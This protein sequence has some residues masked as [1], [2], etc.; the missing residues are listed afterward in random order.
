MAFPDT[1][2]VLHVTPSFYPA[3]VY[4]GPI[5]ATYQLCR[6]LAKQGCETRV[7]TT[8]ANGRNEA[9]QV[10]TDK[11]V[12][13]AE[14]FTVRYCARRWRQSVSPMLMRL[15]WPYMSWADV[16][17]LF[18]VYSFPTFPTLLHSR[19]LHK[20]VVWSPLG[21]LQRWQG[22]SRRGAKAAWDFLW[23]EGVDRSRLILQVS[24]GK[25]K[26]ETLARFPKMRARV[27]PNGVEIP[28]VVEWA[29]R[30]EKLRLLFLG[31]LDPIK[32]IENLLQACSRLSD[33][34]WG[35]TIAGWGAPA[36][37]ARLRER[38]SALGLG[39]RVE[40]AGGVLAEAK[41]KLFESCDVAV[42]PSYKESFGIV[43]AEA[44]A[45]GVPVIAGK[46]TPWSGLEREKCGLWVANDP[47]SLARAIRAI[48][49]MPLQQMGAR[50]RDWMQRDFSW[51]A[52]SRQMLDLYR[53]ALTEGMG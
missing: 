25:E 51:P 19:W 22:S 11:E 45:H 52:I 4:G 8:N 32:G 2:K 50:G 34:A 36:Y 26:D 10:P 17:H 33:F 16:V 48:R 43:V 21:A 6:H 46:G 24:S 31:R 40:M 37:A 30:S 14:G 15:L 27:I 29:G 5:D 47:E 18:Y 13:F 35:L 49:V 38:I 53:A 28:A 3:H 12:L 39:G 20:P 7:L 1:I 41:R 9:L 44:L 42:V 23:Y